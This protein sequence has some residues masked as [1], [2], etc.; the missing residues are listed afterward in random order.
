VYVRNN[1][2]WLATGDGRDGRRLL[3]PDT[4]RR[5]YRYFWPHMLPGGDRA[6]ITID[7]SPGPLIVDSLRLGLVSLNDGT[8][9]WDRTGQRVLFMGGTETVREVVSRAWNR[10]S[11]DRVPVPTALTACLRFLPV[12]RAVSPHFV[13]PCATT[14]IS[15]SHLL[16]HSSHCGRSSQQR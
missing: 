15:T 6:L 4:P 1:E 7:R 2:L 11:D 9:A 8:V 13:P 3:S 14:A 16:T 10:S 5:M 12:R